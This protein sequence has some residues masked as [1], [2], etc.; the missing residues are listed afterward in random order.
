MVAAG[1][2]QPA[3]PARRFGPAASLVLAL[4]VFS[5]MKWSQLRPANLLGPTAQLVRAAELVG[6]RGGGEPALR[7]AEVAG[8]G[9]SRVQASADTSGGGG[10]SAGARAAAQPGRDGRQAAAKLNTHPKTAE[11][12]AVKVDGKPST[13]VQ[14]AAP[15]GSAAQPAAPSPG[16]TEEKLEQVATVE[17]GAAASSQLGSQVLRR[18]EATPFNKCRVTLFKPK[19]MN[20]TQARPGVQASRGGNAVLP[21]AAAP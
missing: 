5:C 18:A 19:P 21:T 15:A 9:A 20:D 12:G 3:R 13:G 8:P 16:A 7:Q 6:A 17:L 2:Q 1:G 14:A 4:I 10:G 11:H